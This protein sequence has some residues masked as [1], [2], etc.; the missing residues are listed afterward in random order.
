MFGQLFFFAV[1]APEKLPMPIVR[2]TEE[3]DR[4]LGVLERR[5]EKVAYLGD[6]DYSIADMCAYPWIVV[7]MTL[8]KDVLA[9]KMASR[10]ALQRWI[11]AVGDRPAVQ[12]AIA[13]ST[14]SQ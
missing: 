14:K 11:A 1:R 3:S 10:P 4:L 9:E 8:I 5:L 12:K 2:F 7:G 13:I 6:T